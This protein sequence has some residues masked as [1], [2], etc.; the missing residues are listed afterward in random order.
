ML[1]SNFAVMEETKR[2]MALWIG[3]DPIMPNAPGQIGE[4][5]RGF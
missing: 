4:A 5:R 1:A 2:R 3:P